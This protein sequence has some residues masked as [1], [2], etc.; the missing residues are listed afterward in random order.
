MRISLTATDKCLARIGQEK[1]KKCLAP[2]QNREHAM[3]A[4]EIQEQEML[5]VSKQSFHIL[6][7]VCRSVKKFEDAKQCL[8][9]IEAYLDEQRKHDD[10]FYNNT[11]SQLTKS[12]SLQSTSSVFAL[13]GECLCA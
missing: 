5:V 1:A 8:D 10:E 6:S 4:L 12:L 11:M 7:H 2:S 13:E 9:R 3:H